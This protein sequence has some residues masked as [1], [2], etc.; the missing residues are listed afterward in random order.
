MTTV[1]VY[2]AKSSFSRLLSRA[3]AGETLVLARNGKPV[4]QLGPIVVRPRPVVFGDLR[5]RVR[6]PDDFDEW[7]SQDELDWYGS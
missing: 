6:L 3:E 7:S 1:N 2:E 5:G 4:A